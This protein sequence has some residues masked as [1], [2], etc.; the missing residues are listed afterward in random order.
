MGKVEEVVTIWDDVART[1]EGDPAYGIAIGVGASVGGRRCL[2]I[3]ID[4]HADGEDSL[5]IGWRARAIGKGAFALGDGMIAEGDHVV[6]ASF[7]F[8]PEQVEKLRQMLFSLFPFD[9]QT[10]GVQSVG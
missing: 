9:Q 7:D 5:A 8:Q 1:L 4:S 10:R 6:A 3:G 2:A